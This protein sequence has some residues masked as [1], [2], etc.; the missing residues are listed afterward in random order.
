MDNGTNTPAGGSVRKPR[1]PD[2]P[3]IKKLIDDAAAKGAVLPRTVVELSESIRDLQIYDDEKGLGGCCALH[4][5]MENLAEIRSIVVRED[6]R[7]QGV[8]KHL[9]EACIAEARALGVKRVYALTRIEAFFAR[10]GF[11]EIDKHDLPSKVF[12]DCVRC[13]K[14]PDCD[15]T[16]VILD[17]E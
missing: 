8:G 2:V 16:A 4:I 17:L 9:L 3:A 13:P 7:G 12:R 14:F 1:L 6:L 10:H 11:S 15:E 5:D